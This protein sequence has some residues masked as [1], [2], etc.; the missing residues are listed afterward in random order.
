MLQERA[1]QA[2]SMLKVQLPVQEERRL[3]EYNVESSWYESW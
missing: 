1:G 2:N 3:R